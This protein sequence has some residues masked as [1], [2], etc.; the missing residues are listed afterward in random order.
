MA[1][2]IKTEA[3]EIDTAQ[4]RLELRIA[5]G[6][7]NLTWGETNSRHLTSLMVANSEFAQGTYDNNCHPNYCVLGSDPTQVKHV[8]VVPCMEEILHHL[9]SAKHARFGVLC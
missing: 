5:R 9:Q 2:V 4:R 8:I 3:H 1:F 7:K 6:C